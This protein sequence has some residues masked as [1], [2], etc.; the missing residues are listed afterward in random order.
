MPWK[1]NQKKNIPNVRCTFVVF[2]NSNEQ[3]KYWNI[4][5]LFLLAIERMEHNGKIRL[6]PFFST[7][8]KIEKIVRSF[9][10][11]LCCGK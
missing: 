4:F 10:F 5:Y 2:L 3:A 1:I 6:R 9:L 8:K 7:K 11:R